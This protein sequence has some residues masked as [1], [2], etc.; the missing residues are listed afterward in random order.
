MQTAKNLFLWPGRNFLRK[1]AEAYLTPWLEIG[2]SKQ[3]ILEIYVN[4]AEWGPGIYGAEAAARTHFGKT[5]AELSAG[6]AALLAAVLP[7]PR[8]WSPAKPSTYVRARARTI[9]ARMA[10]A[11]VADGAICPAA[12]A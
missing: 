2:W 5:A 1:A 7:N 9:R 4:V 10:D 6:E 11:P 3:R 12:P 8:E